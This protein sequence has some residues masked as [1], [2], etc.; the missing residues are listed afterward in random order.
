MT[1]TTLPAPSVDLRGLRQARGLSQERVARLAGCSTSMVRQLERGY[2]P[3]GS[4][5]LP[6]VVEALIEE[7]RSADNAT[8][9]ESSPGMRRLETG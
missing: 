6:R 9:S 1:A 8:A 3:V 7:G 2:V 5:V 4:A